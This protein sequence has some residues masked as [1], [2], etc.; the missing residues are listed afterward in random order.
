QVADDYY[1][2]ALKGWRVVRDRR[3]E[4]T[5]LQALALNC[6]ARNNLAE[7]LKRTENAIAIVEELRT[8]ILAPQL[9]ASY[10][11]SARDCYDLEIDLLMQLHRQNPNEGFD[12]RALEISE[13]SR[14]RV[15]LE[16]LGEAQTT[17]SKA[18]DASLAERRTRV[19]H[20][21]NAKAS[22]RLQMSDAQHE[23]AS[24]E[25]E[26]Q[27]LSEELEDLDAQIG[28]ANRQYS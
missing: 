25:R 17:L 18:S 6:R 10:F 28:A 4:A 19:I 27:S 2:Q 26:I 23:T 22:R 5:T 9:R 8:G 7:G 16:T 24:A 3:G 20:L 13:R 1:E 14:A 15:L 12:R 21:L 11:A